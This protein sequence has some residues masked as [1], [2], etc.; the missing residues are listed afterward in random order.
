MLGLG[1]GGVGRVRYP[2]GLRWVSQRVQ[3]SL[4]SSRAAMLQHRFAGAKYA[5]AL[6]A[7]LIFL[8]FAP[9]AKSEIFGR[10]Q[11]KLGRARKLQAVSFLGK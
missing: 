6:A 1:A 7:S 9:G 2:S 11:G 3:V 8:L 4:D 10:V 5:A